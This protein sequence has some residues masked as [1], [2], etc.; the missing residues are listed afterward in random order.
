MEKLTNAFHCSSAAFVDL[1]EELF[2]TEREGSASAP[3]TEPGE[4][5]IS[6]LSPAIETKR[7][8]KYLVMYAR[9]RISLTPVADT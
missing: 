4:K 1:I 5:A 3:E 2:E 8:N 6:Q 7:P 9:L